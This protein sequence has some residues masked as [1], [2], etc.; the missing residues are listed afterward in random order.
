MSIS[1]I[2]KPSTT[3][4]NTS[5]VSIGETWGSILTTWASETRT[6][7]AISQLIANVAK[8][9]NTIDSYSETNQSQNATSI[10]SGD[11]TQIGQAFAN[12]YQSVIS[13]AKF[14]LKT[15]GTPTGTM[16]AK[17]YALTGT[18]GT[19]A[20]PTGSALATSDLVNVNTLTSSYA[21]I[22][23]N[24]STPFTMDANTN[25]GIVL[26]ASA[27]SGSVSAYV[28]AGMD[29]T[30][31]THTGN[32]FTQTSGVYTADSARDFCFYVSGIY[33]SAITNISK[34]S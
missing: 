28:I 32:R 8:V 1:N 7:L 12:T 19:T 11:I 3:I 20:V 14:Y 34:P 4:A 15:T 29:N 6:W 31:P 25:Y 26:D 5:K 24:F 13:S 23:F 17:L 21:L 27:V 10:Y 16:T 9:I 22:T 18:F 30:S 33:N 2:S